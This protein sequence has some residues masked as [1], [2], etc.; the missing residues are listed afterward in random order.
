MAPTIGSG[1]LQ[2]AM[3]GLV[4]GTEVFGVMP[5]NAAG[6][7]GDYVNSEIGEVLDMTRAA[8]EGVEGGAE[9][10]ALQVFLRHVTYVQPWVT[11]DVNL[12]IPVVPPKGLSRVEIAVTLRTSVMIQGTVFLPPDVALGAMIARTDE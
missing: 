8:T 9:V 7:V 1:R 5:P 2:W 12:D 11:A 3:V 4:T 10:P 6:R